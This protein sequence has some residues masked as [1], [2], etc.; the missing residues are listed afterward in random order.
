MR[1]LNYVVFLF[2]LLPFISCRNQSAPSAD[3]VIK[4]TRDIKQK[5]L[6]DANQISDREVF[7]SADNKLTLYK[8]DIRLKYFIFKNNVDTSG[9]KSSIDTTISCFYSSDQKFE[10]ER[11]ND[12]SEFGSIYEVLNYKSIGAVGLMEFWFCNGKIHEK[13]FRY[14]GEHVGVY[15][16]YNYDGSINYEKDYDNMKLL[17]KLK[18]IKYYR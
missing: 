15:T 16:I 11:N 13:G 2:P 1:R 4:W 8:G 5:I 17:N 14:K 6:E 3:F 7:D 18:Y 12:C 10:L 9:N